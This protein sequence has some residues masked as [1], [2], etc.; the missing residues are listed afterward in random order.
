[1]KKLAFGTLLMLFFS[2]QNKDKN[3]TLE[4]VNYSIDTVF[5]D[6]KGEILDLKYNLV[7]SGFSNDKRTLYNL[8]HFDFSLEKIDLTQKELITKNYFQKNG[9]SGIGSSFT[10]FHVFSDNSFL[11]SNDFYSAKIFNHK[12][13]FIKKISLRDKKWKGERLKEEE[14]SRKK[15]FLRNSTARL[16]TIISKEG[17]LKSNKV[18]LA[19]LDSDEGLISRFNIDPEQKFKSHSLSSTDN[20][21]MSPRIYLSEENNLALVSHEFTNEIY[22][23]DNLSQ[24]LQLVD[25]KSNL[26]PNEVELKINNHLG[27]KE[28]FFEGYMSMLSQIRF[29][30]VTYD[31]LNEQYYRLSYQL[32]FEESPSQNIAFPEASKRKTFITVFDKEF[33]VITEALIPEL[34]F[35]ITNYFAKDG[36]IWIFNNYN[37]ELVFIRLQININE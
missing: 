19:V 14:I 5:I 20:H 12:G 13:D 34:D 28:E 24:E 23:F 18:E 8:N 30:P 16:F 21:Y 33:N 17:P 9:P 36:K 29:G 22:W 10:S 4:P 35:I 25:Y 15:I 26:T 3:Q 32:E 37:D 1:M 6:S 11:I 7:N 27:T 2:C 31:E